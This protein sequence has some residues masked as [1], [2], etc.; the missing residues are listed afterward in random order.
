VIHFFKTLLANCARCFAPRV[1]LWHLVAFALTFVCVWSGLDWWW[2]MHSRAPLTQAVLLPAAVIGGLLPMVLPWVVYG[3]G[4]TLQNKKLSSTGLAILQAELLAGFISAAYKSVTGR[5]EP[6]LHGFGA[7]VS[8][9]AVDNSHAFNF[10]FWEHGIFWGWP[11][12]HTTLA[13]AAMVT[14]YTLFPQHKLVRALA[15]GYAFYIGI[16]ISTNIHWFSDFVAGAI[17][18]SVIGVVVG[19]SFKMDSASAKA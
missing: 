11:S 7:V 3:V 15:L 6:P 13:F 4:R 12:T 14:I 1:F 18:G 16:G 9:T 19:K 5:I 10:G 17:I 8:P 2:F